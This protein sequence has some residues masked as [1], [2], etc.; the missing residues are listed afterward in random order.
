M[1]KIQKLKRFKK[2]ILISSFSFFFIKGLVWLA[3]VL[4]AMFGIS[5]I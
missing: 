1:I 3:I 5:K 4:S 2:L